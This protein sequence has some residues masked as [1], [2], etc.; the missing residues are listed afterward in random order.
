M[1]AGIV[2]AQRIIVRAQPQ[3]LMQAALKALPKRLELLAVANLSVFG[4]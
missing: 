3:G 4:D 1:T 2:D